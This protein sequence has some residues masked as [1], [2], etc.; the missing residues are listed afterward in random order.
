MSLNAAPEKTVLPPSALSCRGVGK[1]YNGENVLFDVDLDVPAGDFAALTGLSGAGKSTLFRILAGMEAPDGGKVFLNGEDVTGTQ[2]LC[3]CMTQKDALFDHFSVLDNVALPLRIKKQNRREARDE[4]RPFLRRFG[5]GDCENK[6]PFEI[7]GGMRQRAALLR[8]F[9][10]QKKTV[11]LDEPFSALDAI[12][13]NNIHEWYKE[14]SVSFSLSTFCITHDI[15]EA[16]KLA[17]R[18]YVIGGKPGKIKKMFLIPRRGEEA[19][20][21][22]SKEAFALKREICRELEA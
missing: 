18:I 8:T 4:A 3:G 12:T 19:S 22:E 17:D 11:L 9:M 16:I 2:G 6:Y 21:L 20:F 15:D 7:S 5:L 13:R 14:A 10:C 1:S